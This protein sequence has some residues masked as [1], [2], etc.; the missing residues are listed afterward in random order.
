MSPVQTPKLVI[1]DCDGVLVDSET[2][3]CRVLVDALAG[4]G[5]EISTAEAIMSFSGF[6]PEDTIAIAEDMLGHALPDNFWNEMQIK[7]FDLFKT[8][9]CPI[10]G[11]LDLVAALKTKGISVCV[12]SSGAHQKMNLT[13]RLSGLEDS[14]R[15]NV[16]S[17]D[18]VA[19]GK[20]APDLFLYAARQ[21]ECQPRDCLVIE[22]SRPGIEAAIAAGMGAVLFDPGGKH[23]LWIDE[24]ARVTSLD[25]ILALIG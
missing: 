3:A 24:V 9:L 2:I 8:K 25:Q 21:M 23:H 22:D 11:A 10:E 1:F 4:H 20:P 14:I 18:D 7:T 5:L 15:P 19:R 6:K 16:F 17:A 12:A 13:L